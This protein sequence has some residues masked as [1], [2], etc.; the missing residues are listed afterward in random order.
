LAEI[1][2]G[3][4]DWINGSYRVGKPGFEKVSRIDAEFPGKP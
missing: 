1:R 3:Y 2:P 4:L